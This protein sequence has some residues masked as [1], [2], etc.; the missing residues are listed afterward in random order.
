MPGLCIGIYFG[1]WIIKKKNL[2]MKGVSQLIIIAN[3]ITVA[4]LLLFLFA[5]CGNLPIAGLTTSYNSS[6]NE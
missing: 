6:H 3:I 1:G 5:G 4:L 2:E